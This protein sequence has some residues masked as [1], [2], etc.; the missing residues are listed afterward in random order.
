MACSEKEKEYARKWYHANKER[1]KGKRRAYHLKNRE[2]IIQKVKDWNRK[3][4]EKKNAWSRATWK[5]YFKPATRKA[6]YEKNKDYLRIQA[7]ERYR[8]QD[9]Y[10]T[11]GARKASARRRAICAWADFDK[12]T[13]IYAEARRLTKETGTE[14]VVD[15]VVPIK[16]KLVCGLTNEFNLRVIP[17]SENAK[18]KNK[19][20]VET[21]HALENS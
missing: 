18:K 13:A 19:F 9:K 21:F 10:R 6:W 14:H 5:K 12:V 15:H 4:R 8:T 17:N 16:H 7:R 11:D 1:L 20:V 3:N 2:R